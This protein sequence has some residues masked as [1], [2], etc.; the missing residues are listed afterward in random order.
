[1]DIIFPPRHVVRRNVSS[2][3]LYMLSFGLV[4]VASVTT[5]TEPTYCLP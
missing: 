5:D 4:L 2:D 1:M 3:R